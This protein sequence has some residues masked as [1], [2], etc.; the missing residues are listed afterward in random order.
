MDECR[1]TDEVGFLHELEAGLFEFEAVAVEGAALVRDEDDAFELVDLD[2]EL[3]LIDDTLFFE[4]GLRMPGK[5][6]GPARQAKPVVSGE[7]EAVLEEVVEVFAQSAVGAV[8]GRGMDAGGVVLEF[9][10]V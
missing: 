7:V 10:F 6:G 4:V 2:E 5:A 1:G 9:G 3:E 8:E